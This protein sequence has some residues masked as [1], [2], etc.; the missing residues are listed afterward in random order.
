[1]TA[2]QMK[3][4]VELAMYKTKYLRHVDEPDDTQ[5]ISLALLECEKAMKDVLDAWVT[6]TDCSVALYAVEQTLKEIGSK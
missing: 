1:M 6:K 2:E 5:I 3:E 4:A